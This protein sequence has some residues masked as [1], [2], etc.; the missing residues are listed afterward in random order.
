MPKRGSGNWV[1][2]TFGRLTVVDS[3]GYVMAGS[4][5]REQLRC[6][7][8]CGTEILSIP[9]KLTSG[10]TTSCGCLN[11]ERRITHG[12]SKAPVYKVWCAMRDRCANP[13]N[14]QYG[15][16]GARGISVCDRWSNSYV[17]FRDD[18]GPRPRG[19]TLERIDTNGNY[20]PS[21]CRW[22][23]HLEQMNNTRETVRLTL[24]GETK[25]LQDWARLL[26]VSHHRLSWRKRAGWSDEDA[27][28]KPWSRGER[29]DLY[30]TTSLT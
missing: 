5:L 17:A 27:L 15:N 22:A 10:N 20:E 3:V 2:R 18:M 13:R 12:E 4:R 1:G 25:S 14:S 9:G 8:I 24:N 16:Y 26:G 7:C 11:K 28:T 21:N 30:R 29:R 6:S 23:T 19:G